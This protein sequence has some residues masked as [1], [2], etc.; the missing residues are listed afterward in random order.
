[1][2]GGAF[3]LGADDVQVVPDP[4][5]PLSP[6]RVA[7]VRTFAIDVSEVT[8]GRYRDALARG[9]VP[10][11]PPTATEGELGTTPETT[12]TFSAAPRGREEFALSC[13]TWRTAH[14]YCMFL[15]G[16]LPT[17]A[18]W[19]YAATSASRPGKA[20]FPWG[21]DAPGCARAVYGRLTLAGLPGGCEKEAGTGPLPVS[22]GGAPVAPGDVSAAHVQGLGGGVAEWTRDSPAAYD[23]PCWRGIDASCTD[24]S[25]DAHVV[26]GGAWASTAINVRSAARLAS[27]KAT[28]FIGFRCVYP[29]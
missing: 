2:E 12:C 15:G 25:S 24:A 7:R 3:V 13:V 11:D 6:E 21:D 1:V 20:T 29:D 18:Q 26:R 14:A 16:D 27:R 5:L 10:A 28:S 22:V 19:E 8:V 4:S 17:E 9:F 23:S